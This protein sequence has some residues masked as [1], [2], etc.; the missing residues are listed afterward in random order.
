MEFRIFLPQLRREE[1]KLSP[2]YSEYERVL[3][4]LMAAF[5]SLNGSIPEN[6]EDTYL[7]GGCHFGVK[8]RA[9]KKLEIK[10]RTAKLNFNVEQW[11]KVKLGKKTVSHYKDEILDLISQDSDQQ[12]PE[13]AQ[14]IMA[15]KFLKVQKSRRTKLLGDISKEICHISIPEND[16]LWISFAI[17]GSLDGIHNFLCA[18]AEI[19]HDSYLLIEALRIAAAIARIDSNFL[20]VVAGY[21]TWVRV[22][23]NSLK[24][25]DEF[26]S[27]LRSV[28]AFLTEVKSFT[29]VIAES[30]TGSSDRLIPEQTQAVAAAD[31][32][33]EDDRKCCFKFC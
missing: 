32:N 20:P 16:R 10:I 4:S 31:T 28:D 1:L 15:E 18:R 3:S 21:P 12:L 9:G 19:Y 27:I 23:S 17:E 26:Y 2:L 11:K 13:D 30:A 7:I 29:K 25:E 8:N 22:A 5:G 33:F 6:R 24:N 14:Y